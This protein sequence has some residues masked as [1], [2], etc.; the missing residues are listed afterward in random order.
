MNLFASILTLV[1]T[2]APKV[3]LGIETVV[4]EA[5]SGATKRKMA[6]DA[7]NAAAS[8]A[9]SALPAGSDNA[10]YAT[11][12]TGAVSAIINDV[13]T[14]SGIVNT[15]KASGAYQAATA[16]AKAAQ[17]KPKTEDTPKEG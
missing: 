11:A 15:T 12:A 13:D 9:A 17:V 14:I 6:Q 1:L 16:K 5:Q 4:G 8:A 3:I 7:L 2:L 10:A